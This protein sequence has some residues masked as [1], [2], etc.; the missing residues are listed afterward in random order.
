MLL[1]CF[2]F[3]F[4]EVSLLPPFLVRAWIG[5]LECP[6]RT[7]SLGRGGSQG[8]VPCF[9]NQL[10]VA[11][12]NVFLRLGPALDGGILHDLGSGLYFLG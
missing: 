11:D 7:A 4:V 10:G 8:C 2:L 1:V 3:L 5:K 9:K 12:A 6:N